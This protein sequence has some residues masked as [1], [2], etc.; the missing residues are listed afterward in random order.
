M[1]EDLCYPTWISTLVLLCNSGPWTKSSQ[2]Y[3][4]YCTYR[5]HLQ[6]TYGLASVSP[7]PLLFLLEWKP[8]LARRPRRICGTRRT[9]GGDR[10]FSRT[11]LPERGHRTEWVEAESGDMWSGASHNMMTSSDGNF[12]RVNSPVNSP[13]KGQGRGALMFSFIWINGWLNNG[14]AGDL[15]RH[16]A[17]YDV[18]V[19]QI[20][21]TK[22]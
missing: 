15:R 1:L 16:S 2:F 4:I 14:D 19:M 18:T 8:Q 3:V 12:L 10:I 9:S 5:V 13:H 17:H 6:T 7:R 22:T 21:L 11:N 20:L